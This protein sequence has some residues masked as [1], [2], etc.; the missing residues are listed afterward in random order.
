[1]TNK[2]TNFDDLPDSAFV[3]QPTVSMLCGG[4]DRA[5]LYKWVKAGTFPAP[6]KLSPQTTAWNVGD[7]RRH[8]SMLAAA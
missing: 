7:L 6:K 5:T 4:T 3:R 8:F 1:M 2:N